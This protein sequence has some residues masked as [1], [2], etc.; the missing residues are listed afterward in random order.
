[1]L[2][3]LLTRLLKLYIKTNEEYLLL[4]SEENITLKRNGLNQKYG[5]IVDGFKILITSRKIQNFCNLN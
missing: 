5:Q 3:N 1:M 2:L 4:S